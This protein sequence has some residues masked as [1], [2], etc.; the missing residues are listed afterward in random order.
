[1]ATKPIIDPITGGNAEPMYE[2][3]KRGNP[4]GRCLV[5]GRACDHKNGRGEPAIGDCESCCYAG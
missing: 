1:M 4:I 2:Y 5:T 3:P